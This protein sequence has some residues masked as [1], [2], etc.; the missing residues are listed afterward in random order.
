[1]AEVNVA[2]ELTNVLKEILGEEILERFMICGGCIM[3][4]YQ[5]YKVKDVD[6]ILEYDHF[7]SNKYKQL[8]KD[9]FKFLVY[10]AIPKEDENADY[11]N[12]KISTFI[13]DKNNFDEQI[14]KLD[15]ML[16]TLEK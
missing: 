10:C 5:D 16:A 6:V 13:I 1:M 12:V 15:E 2:Q 11:I 14:N 7:D 8:L 4:H 3:Y 9:N